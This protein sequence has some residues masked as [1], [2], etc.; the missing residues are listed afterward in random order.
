MKV[1]DGFVDVKDKKYIN[2]KS[3]MEASIEELE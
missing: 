2:N 3:M 1:L